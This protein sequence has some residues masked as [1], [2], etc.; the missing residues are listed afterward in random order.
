MHAEANRSHLIRPVSLLQYDYTG[1]LRDAN[2]VP[3]RVTW[4][5][6][7]PQTGISSSITY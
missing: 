6:E 2:D 4:L 3:C 7:S 1:N 5:G